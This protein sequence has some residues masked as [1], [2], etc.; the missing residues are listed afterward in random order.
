MKVYSNDESKDE[1]QGAAFSESI[2]CLGK[3]HAEVT[4]TQAG[5]CLNT[6][7]RAPTHF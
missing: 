2:R 6:Q 4:L 5:L 7:A 3:A 1:S